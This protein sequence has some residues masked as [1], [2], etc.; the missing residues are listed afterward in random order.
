MKHSNNMVNKKGLMDPIHIITG[1]LLI[2]GGVLYLLNQG[3]WGLIIASIG[4]LT[5]A[6]KQVVK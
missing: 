6:I 5:E 3:N 2:L 4:L 1:V